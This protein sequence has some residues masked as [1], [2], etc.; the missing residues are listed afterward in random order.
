MRVRDGAEQRAKRVRLLLLD[1]D[2]VLTDGRILLDPNGLELKS[3]SARDGLGI[4]LAREAGLG[5]GILSGRRSGAVERR[6]S[7]LRL[8]EVHQGVLDKRRV[9]E[10]LLVRQRLAA[11][12]V[13]YMGD[14]LVDLPVLQMAGLAA[15]VPDAVAE[16]LDVA[17]LVTGRPGGDGAVREVIE[18]VLKARGDWERLLASYSGGA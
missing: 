11:E 8:E 17:Q 6:A 3:F 16:V 5:I 15:T 14:D 9:F 12:E 18:F 4:R 7:E 2:G 13:A 1:A 10:T